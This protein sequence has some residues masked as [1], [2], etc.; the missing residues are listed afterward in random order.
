MWNLGRRKQGRSRGRRNKSKK[1]RRATKQ[2]LNLAKPKL[3]KEIWPQILST[4][5]IDDESFFIDDTDTKK[6]TSRPE[7]KNKSPLIPAIPDVCFLIADKYG[8]SNRFITEFAAG[9]LSAHGDLSKYAL[10]VKTTERRRSF[11]RS[12]YAQTYKTNQI[13]DHQFHFYA[14]KFCLRYTRIIF[15]TLR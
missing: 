15:Q 6:R 9:F 4:D 13:K 12:N 11:V 2:I 10:S 14:L 7:P 1:R 8:A 5:N 3:S